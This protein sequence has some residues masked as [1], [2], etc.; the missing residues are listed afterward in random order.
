MAGR[1]ILQ[2]GLFVLSLRKTVYLLTRAELSTETTA[3]LSVQSRVCARVLKFANRQALSMNMIM[4]EAWAHLREAARLTKETA[5]ETARADRTIRRLQEQTERQIEKNARGLEQLKIQFDR[6]GERLGYMTE[7]LALPSLETILGERFGMTGFTR[8]ALVRK[9]A[10]TMQLDLLAWANG[11]IN[12]V[13]VAE[14]KSRINLGAVHQI[15]RILGR[16]RVF[17]PEHSSKKLHGILAG[18]TWDPGAAERA[19]AEGLLIAGIQDELFRLETP[20]GFEP[21]A[22]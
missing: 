10:D 6:L 19:M 2:C 21:R 16:F 7:D 11:E 4:E 1:R 14:V 22:W 9:G 3:V 12:T 13:I 20:D 8:R 5:K 18:V 17:F 15:Q